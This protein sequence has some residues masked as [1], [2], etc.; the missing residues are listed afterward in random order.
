MKQR[1]RPIRFNNLSSRW[2]NKYDEYRQWLVAREK[3]GWD[4]AHKIAFDKVKEEIRAEEDRQ[5]EKSRCQSA[6][7]F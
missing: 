4:A 7:L 6:A 3:M 5:A 2:K 1:R